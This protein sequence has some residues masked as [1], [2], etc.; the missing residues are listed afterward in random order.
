MTDFR[1]IL[2]LRSLGLSQRQIASVVK[3]SRHTVAKV[4]SQAGFTF[5]NVDFPGMNTY[6]IHTSPHFYLRLHGNPELFKSSYSKESLQSFYAQFPEGMESYTVYF[7]N[8][9]YEAGYTNALQLI[10]LTDR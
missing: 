10:D 2:R 7:N 8:T 1:E 3:A 5:C 4:F 9:Y 6:F